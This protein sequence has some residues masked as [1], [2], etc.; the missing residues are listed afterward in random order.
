MRICLEYSLTY[1]VH[2]LRVY[3]RILQCTSHNLECA[4]H[5][6]KCVFH[7]FILFTVHTLPSRD[8]HTTYTFTQYM[9]SEY[10]LY[11]I[12]H[13]TAYYTR[14]G[15]R[16]AHTPCAETNFSGLRKPPR[17]EDAITLQF[18]VRYTNM[19]S[20]GGQ[21]SIHYY[22]LRRRVVE[23]PGR[24]QQRYTLREHPGGVGVSSAT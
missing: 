24:S 1:S 7:N 13:Q 12:W 4:S 18:F 10:F 8:H 3:I 6:L 9:R 16:I 11:C 20:K 22:C 15:A 23:L 14:V 5:N 21:T 2:G 17:H 19:L